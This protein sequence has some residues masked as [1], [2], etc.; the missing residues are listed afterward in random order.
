MPWKL[1]PSESIRNYT[2]TMKFYK[3][4]IPTE[5]WGEVPAEYKEYKK[6]AWNSCGGSWAITPPYKS[7]YES[8][9]HS[10]FFYLG[11]EKGE[12]K[13]GFRLS[14]DPT[15]LTIVERNMKVFVREWAEDV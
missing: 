15:P 2:T 11:F 3:V 8:H 14:H 7:H 9:N 13:I 6:W 10:S 5:H 1:K 4:L 12:D